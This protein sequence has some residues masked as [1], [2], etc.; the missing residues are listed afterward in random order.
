MST[1]YGIPLI[2]VGGVVVVVVLLWS[3]IM[4]RLE[5]RFVCLFTIGVGCFI[6]GM[7]VLFVVQDN[8][9]SGFDLG[10]FLDGYVPK[11]PSV[12]FGKEKIPHQHQI[13]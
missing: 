11:L 2:A 3:Q 13:E 10:G 8:D 1:G 9:V 7:I 4:Q 5:V 6:A 12:L